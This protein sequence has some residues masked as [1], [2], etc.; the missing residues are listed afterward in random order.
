VA[1]YFAVNIMPRDNTIRPEP[2]QIAALVEAWR[3]TGYIVHPESFALRE[4][5]RH[6]LTHPGLETG[7]WYFP[8]GPFAYKTEPRASSVKA[9]WRW[10]MGRPPQKHFV[11]GQARPFPIPPDAEA[12]AYLGC[13]DA[14][15]H[16]LITPMS[17][18]RIAN[19][20]P[21]KE[22]L[23]KRGGLHGTQSSAVPKRTG[24]G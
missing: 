9:M 11:N 2:A 14:S 15:I 6:E 12:L 16:F 3:D 7:A 20:F 1:Y 18:P 10:L 13:S 5:Y 19:A 22:K 24:A 21:Y 8:F 4:M 23:A 17:P